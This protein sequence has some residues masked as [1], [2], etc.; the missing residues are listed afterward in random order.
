MRLEQLDAR[1]V[2]ANDR[3]GSI[4]QNVPF[5][6]AQGI[7]FLC[8]KCFTENLA[9]YGDGAHGT[10]SVLVWFAGRGTPADRKPS[11]RWGVSGNDIQNL[12]LD[13]S[14]W[15]NR[16]APPDAP[17]DPPVCRWH[18]WVKNGDAA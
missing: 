10:H 13:P 18:G 15:I 9:K 3:A 6:L 2:R 17:G 1:F 12:T 5:D 11:P 16:D 7:L 8:P 4:S 14:I